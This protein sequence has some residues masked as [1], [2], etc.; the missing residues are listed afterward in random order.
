MLFFDKAVWRSIVI[1]RKNSSSNC[2]FQLVFCISNKF[3]IH[4]NYFE[5]FKINFFYIYH[6]K[7]HSEVWSVI[8]YKP[9]NGC[10]EEFINELKRLENYEGK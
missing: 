5:L 10:K 6:F 2:K 8:K 3:V 4:F 9:K 7:C 1:K